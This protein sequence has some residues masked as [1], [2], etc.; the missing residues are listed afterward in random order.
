[1]KENKYLSGFSIAAYIYI[2]IDIYRY[3]KDVCA[4]IAQTPWISQYKNPERKNLF[5]WTFDS[6]MK[7]KQFG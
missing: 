3:T 6:V 1:M 7:R 5:S 4:Y 2:H